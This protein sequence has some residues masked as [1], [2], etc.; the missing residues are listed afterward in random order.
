MLSKAK[1]ECCQ[2]L[3]SSATADNELIALS[4]G[5]CPDQDQDSFI[6]VWS[7]R[8]L[9]GDVSDAKAAYL[10]IGHRLSRSSVV[11]VVGPKH[12]AAKEK[13]RQVTIAIQMEAACP[14]GA[15]HH[16]EPAVGLLSLIENQLS[17]AKS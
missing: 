9:F 1:K 16:F 5:H 2:L 14:N 13:A 6:Q 15:M 4:R 10:Y 3:R 8:V 17:C 12:I 7:W 11:S